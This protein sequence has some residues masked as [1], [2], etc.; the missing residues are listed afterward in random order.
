MVLSQFF[1]TSFVFIPAIYAQA[2]LSKKLGLFIYAMYI[3]A[4]IL[5]II[6]AVRFF[7]LYFYITQIG[8]CFLN[9]PGLYA[10]KQSLYIAILNLNENNMKMSSYKSIHN[11]I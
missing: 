11:S 9:H 1:L 6:F 8:T 2:N 5:Y 4:A 10:L 7:I 3:P